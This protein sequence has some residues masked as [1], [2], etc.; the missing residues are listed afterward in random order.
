MKNT[1]LAA[2]AALSLTATLLAGSEAGAG[3]IPEPWRER[4]KLRTKPFRLAFCSTMHYI[5]CEAT[6]GG[7]NGAGIIDNF[8]Q[9]SGQNPAAPR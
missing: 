2:A 3:D 7:A 6:C 8:A 4:V 1:M 5:A 9:A